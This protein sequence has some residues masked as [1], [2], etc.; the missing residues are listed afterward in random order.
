MALT[1][2]EECSSELSSKAKTCPN[3]GFDRAE[4]TAIDVEGA[5]I[6]ITIFPVFIYFLICLS[7]IYFGFFDY[8]NAFFSHSYVGDLKSWLWWAISF[9]FL[10]VGW[11]RHPLYGGW[12]NACAV[13]TVVW[14]I[15]HLMIPAQ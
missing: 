11:N 13:C 1:L 15:V 7:G 12:L 4:N 5:I 10:S 9:L 6:R 3:C 2:C 14:W 8:S